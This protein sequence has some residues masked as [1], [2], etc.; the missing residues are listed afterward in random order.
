[1]DE[2]RTEEDHGSLNPATLFNKAFE[3]GRAKKWQEAIRYY[4]LYLSVHPWNANAINN[5]ADAMRALGQIQAAKELVIWALT[6][7]PHL[8]EGWCTLGELQALAGEKFS[9]RLNYELALSLQPPDGPLHAE[10]Q[11]FLDALDAK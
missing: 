10:T 1:M 9:A 2:Q 8:S 6:L 3:L 7:D 5:K 11:S 4:D